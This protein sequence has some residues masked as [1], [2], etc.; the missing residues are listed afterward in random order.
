M[1]NEELVEWLRENSSGI[2]RPSAEGAERL[3]MALHVIRDVF[4]SIPQRRDWLNPET[5][6]IAKRL[7]SLDKKLNET[8]T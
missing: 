6:R 1:D 4:S 3:D 7:L 8:I 5:E 2:Y